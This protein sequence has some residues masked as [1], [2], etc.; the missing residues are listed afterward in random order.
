MSRKAAVVIGVD[1]TGNLKELKSAAKGAEEVAAWLEREGFDVKCLTDKNSPVTGQ[2]IKDSIR[3]FVTIPVQYHM[4]LV[5]FSGHGQWYQR[6][7]PGG[8]SGHWK[9]PRGFCRFPRAGYFHR[10][11]QGK[12]RRTQ[13]PVS[14]RV[15]FS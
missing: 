11:V 6:S 4:L 9:K 12:Y 3:K 1:K 10:L 5:Y 13:G 15:Y 14:G 2:Q 7:A 8:A